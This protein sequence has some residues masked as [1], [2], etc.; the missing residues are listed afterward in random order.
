MQHISSYFGLIDALRNGDGSHCRISFSIDLCAQ[1]PE[2]FAHLGSH[3][4]NG[5]LLGRI[6]GWINLKDAAGDHLCLI[7]SASRY[8]VFPLGNG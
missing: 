2:F 3:A 1:I 5:L 4:G 7:G 6:E 8:E